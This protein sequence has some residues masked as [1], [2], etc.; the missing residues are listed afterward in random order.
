MELIHNHQ[1]P[2]LPN[3]AGDSDDDDVEFNGVR[4]SKRS[5]KHDKGGHQFKK[6]PKGATKL[7][8]GAW[9]I[10]KEKYKYPTCETRGCKNRVN[11]YCNCKL[12]HWMC[13]Q[14]FGMHCWDAAIEFSKSK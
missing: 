5:I 3:A 14:C 12:G 13:A 4:K 8:H 9:I 1:A 2:P 6:A 11:T 7:A 10:S